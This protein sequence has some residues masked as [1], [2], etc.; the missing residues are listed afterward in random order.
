MLDSPAPPS[1]S[2]PTSPPL[3]PKITLQQQTEQDEAKNTTPTSGIT[4]TMVTLPPASDTKPPETIN[5]I[6]QPSTIVPLPSSSSPPLVPLPTPLSLPPTSNPASVHPEAYNFNGQTIPVKTRRGSILKPREHY[7]RGT[8][9][10]NHIERRTRNGEET[11]PDDLALY[12]RM[13]QMKNSGWVHRRSLVGISIFAQGSEGNDD[14]F[15]VERMPLDL[16]LGF[17]KKIFGILSFQTFIVTSALIYIT[18]FEDEDIIDHYYCPLQP[19]LNYTNATNATEVGRRL[20]NGTIEWGIDMPDIHTCEGWAGPWFLTFFGLIAALFLLYKTKYIF[21]LNYLALLIF[22]CVQTLFFVSIKTVFNT[23]AIVYVSGSIFFQI[24]LMYFFSNR[25]DE[26]QGNLL[27]VNFYFPAIEAAGCNLIVNII[28][29]LTAP[30]LGVSFG[31]FVFAAISAGLMMAWFA[32]DATCMVSKMSPDEY[33]QAVVF[34]YTDIILFLSFMFLM[35]ACLVLGEGGEATACCTDLEF[36]G[37]GAMAMTEMGG[38]GAA[39]AAEGGAGGA[40]FMNVET[41]GLTA[42]IGN[43]EDRMQRGSGS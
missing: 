22:S 33:M 29:A 25:K 4:P 26:A 40:M 19:V 30:S 11:S 27:P 7:R 21:P 17:R 42:P 37:G 20:G 12:H 24:F 13:L 34:F 18:F 2:P 5:L 31:E 35:C 1:S 9:I 41:G 38:G 23:N 14:P 6:S 15:V 8:V 43:Q 32:Y 36:G 28:I 3:S 39:A 16:Q 10:L